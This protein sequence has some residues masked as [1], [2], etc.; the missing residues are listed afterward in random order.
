MERLRRSVYVAFRLTF[1]DF[2]LDLLCFGFCKKRQLCY[3]NRKLFCLVEAE[4]ILSLASFIKNYDICT[5]FNIIETNYFSIV[6]KK[7]SIYACLEKRRLYRYFFLCILY[8]RNSKLSSKLH[9]SVYVEVISR[10]LNF[11]VKCY[12]SNLK[13]K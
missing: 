11:K 3:V 1:R 5:V 10:I 6:G 13:Y 7:V 9:M 2:A 4:K 12:A 8:F